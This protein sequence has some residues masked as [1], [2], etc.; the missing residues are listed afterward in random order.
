MCR[1]VYTI[2]D[3][4]GYLIRIGKNNTHGPGVVCKEGWLLNGDLLEAERTR[5]ANTAT[6]RTASPDNLGLP[7]II[8]KFGAGPHSRYEQMIACSCASHV[9]QVTLARVHFIKVRL[10]SDGLDALIERDHIVVARDY[11]NASEL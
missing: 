1:E 2:E 9:Q 4:L 3:G 11:G 5:S 6:Q 8:K 10:V 7:H